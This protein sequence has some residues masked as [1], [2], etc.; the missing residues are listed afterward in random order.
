MKD[1]SITTLDLLREVKDKYSYL[2]PA[3]YMNC[4]FC[5]LIQDPSEVHQKDCVIEKIN[6]AIDS[7]GCA[8]KTDT[9]KGDDMIERTYVFDRFRGACKMAEGAK[10]LA[11]NHTEAEDKA[12]KLF[13]DRPGR[14]PDTFVLREIMEDFI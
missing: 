4:R 13:T 14:E 7:D 10:V 3:G 5:D 1:K 2:T 9:T 6:G 12:K 8:V 11:H